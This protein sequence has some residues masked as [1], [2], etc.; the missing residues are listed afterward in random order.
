MTQS[1]KDEKDHDAQETKY[2]YT[3]DD[4]AWHRMGLRP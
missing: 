3:S 1:E 4:P 2:L